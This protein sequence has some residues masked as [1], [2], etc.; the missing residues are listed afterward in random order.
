MTADVAP[1]YPSPSIHAPFLRAQLF[2]LAISTEARPGG[3]VLGSER[4]KWS[5]GWGV[6]GGGGDQAETQRWLRPRM[7][8]LQGQR[9]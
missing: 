5:G 9:Q 1:S 2:G 8:G 4:N 3:A 6:G 7:T